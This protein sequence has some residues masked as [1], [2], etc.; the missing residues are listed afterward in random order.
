MP[1]ILCPVIINKKQ[2]TY[3]MELKITDNRY[4][5]VLKFDLASQEETLLELDASLV[6]KPTGD[7]PTWN[8]KGQITVS[9]SHNK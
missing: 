1:T 9:E 8:Y 4:F 2:G 6:S 5:I 7:L 3:P